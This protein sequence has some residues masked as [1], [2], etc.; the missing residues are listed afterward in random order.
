MLNEKKIQQAIDRRLSGLSASDVRRSRIRAATQ[1]DRRE[2]A[3]VKRKLSVAVA[4][5]FAVMMMTSVAVAAGLGLF[6]EIAGMGPDYDRRLNALDVTSTY[7]N[8]TFNLTEDTEPPV[9][10]T[11]EQ[12]H[13]DG[14]RVFISYTLT[15]PISKVCTYTGAPETTEWDQ[16]M[17]DTVAAEIYSSEDPAEQEML[18]SLDGTEPRWGR[19]ANYSVHDGLQLEDGTYL[20][21]IGGDW[22][23]Q[24]DG[25]LVGWKECV[26]PADAAADELNVQIGTFLSDVVYY[27]EGRTLRIDYR[28][29]SKE[30]GLWHTFTV[31]KASDNL[32]LTGTVDA[33]EWS[34]AANMS[35]SAID[36]R[37]EITVKAPQSWLDFWLDWEYSGETP[38]YIHDWYV[39]V[40][41][42]KLD[43]H[44][45]NGGVGAGGEGELVYYVCYQHV[46]PESEI[47]LVPNFSGSG[48]REELA[49]VLTVEK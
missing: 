36:I 18:K 27:Q 20:E 1:R 43:G 37:G 29:S 31:K 24:E 19:S 34:A 45:L 10:L 7:I 25:S 6:G 41:G 39:Y 35:L 48:V 38:D 23:Q 9:E 33:G 3:P 40:D 44:N 49:I 12:A 2:D 4:I 21:I 26:V 47:R 30:T 5:A 14:A 15:G 42:V 22:I 16:V 32:S 17:E 8:K 13:Y 28:T 46:D 11:V